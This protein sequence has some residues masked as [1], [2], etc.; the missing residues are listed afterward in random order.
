[1][2]VFT[3]SWNDEGALKHEAVIQLLI[4]EGADLEQADVKGLRPLDY[5][6]GW[7]QEII[8]VIVRAGAKP[9]LRLA[10]ISGDVATAKQILLSGQDP[11]VVGPYGWTALH[12][13]CEYGNIE[14][15]KLLVDHGG[16]VLAGLDDRVTPLDL[17]GDEHETLRTKLLKSAW[18]K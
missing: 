1:M 6:I 4:S 7:N 2:L 14:V 9:T 3:N 18:G 5:A 17:L 12:F 13:A 10:A 16:D 11:N 15:F 8:D